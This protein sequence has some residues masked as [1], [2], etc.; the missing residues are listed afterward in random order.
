LLTY[1]TLP[2]ATLDY[3]KRTLG[4]SFTH[5]QDTLH[6]KP[7]LPTDL[8]PA[9]IAT[10]VFLKE[11]LKDTYALDGSRVT[12]LGVEYLLTSNVALSEQQR[13]I[14]LQRVTRPDFPHLVD[15]ILTELASK[16]SR[17]F[18]QY[19]IHNRLLLEQLEQ[20]ARARPE[21]MKNDLFVRAWLARLHPGEDTNVEGDAKAREAWLDALWA[22]AKNLSPSF[23]SLKAHILYQR[24][25]H[26][27][28]AGTPNETRFLE[29]LKLPRQMGYVN[30][31]YRENADVFK[32]PAN[33]NED[34]QAITARQPVRNDEPLVRR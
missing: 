11:A 22:F 28:E 34:F 16:D 9:R 7:N 10:E 15:L 27:E 12:D 29:Y 13:R 19:T 3:L 8:D 2:Q 24:L 14:L 5:Q 30:E 20:L 6:P 4:V 33:L 26:D 17:G 32:H 18:G 1:E 23:N 25:V 21:L 31:K